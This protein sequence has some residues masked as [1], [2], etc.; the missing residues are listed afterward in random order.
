MKLRV[1]ILN[2]S[3]RILKIK[4]IA[5]LVILLPSITLISQEMGTTPMQDTSRNSLLRSKLALQYESGFNFSGRSIIPIIFSLKYHLSD[6]SALRFSAGLN[7]GM[8]GMDE[9]RNHGNDT[10]NY[11]QRF[12]G[13]TNNIERV[14]FSLTYLLYPAPKKEINLFFGIG[15]RFGTG[16]QHFRSLD[17]SGVDSMKSHRNTSWSIGLSGLVGAEWFVTR[18]ISLFTE[19]DVAAGYQKRDYWDADYNSTSGTY[20]LT[21]VKSSKVRLTDLSA[22]LGFSIYFDRPF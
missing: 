13:H 8:N 22:R 15:P 20:T 2:K 18:S 12:D 6:K 5:A 16:A 10:I 14:N 7:P 11:N 9:R 4:I 17:I 19:Y 21:E 1:V 3:N